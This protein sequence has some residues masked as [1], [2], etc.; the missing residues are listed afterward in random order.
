M[1]IQLAVLVAPLTG[2][3]FNSPSSY[4]CLCGV[5][6]TGADCGDR[7]DACLSEPCSHGGACRSDNPQGDTLCNCS[8]T[9]YGGDTCGSDLNECRTGAHQCYNGSTCV[10]DAEGSRYTCQCAE[11]KTGEVPYIVWWNVRQGRRPAFQCW[12]LIHIIAVLT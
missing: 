5:S 6:W 11:L 3:C 10:F 12:L 4:F 7:V 1:I 9:G 8:G 2:R